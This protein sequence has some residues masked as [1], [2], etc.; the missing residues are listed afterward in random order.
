MFLVYV[1]DL[2]N[3]FRSLYP[4]M[5]ANHTNLFLN[6]NKGIKHLFAVVNKVLVNIK[7]WVN[8]NKKSLIWKKKILILPISQVRNTISL[9]AYQNL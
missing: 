9:L 6:H 8:A 4:V 1:N 7:N 5:F 2:P 3:V